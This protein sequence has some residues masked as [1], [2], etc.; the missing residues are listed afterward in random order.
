MGKRAAR[1]P[2]QTVRQ[3]DEFF[4]EIL[5]NPQRLEQFSP[6]GKAGK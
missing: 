6:L 3:S 5:R 2:T 4:P 1:E